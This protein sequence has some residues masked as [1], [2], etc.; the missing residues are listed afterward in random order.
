MWYNLPRNKSLKTHKQVTMINQFDKAKSA[1]TS[2]LRRLSTLTSKKPSLPPPAL[3]GAQNCKRSG[4]I[5]PLPPST[6]I[7]ILDLPLEIQLLIFSHLTI[8]DRQALR[9]SSHFF[10]D[11]LPPPTHD[12]LLD[13]ERE[14]AGYFHFHH[15]YPSHEN[16]FSPVPD[17]FDCA[18][19]R[20]LPPAEVSIDRKSVV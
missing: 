8:W 7:P 4:C 11:L 1:V 17:V 16:A 15:T 6:P 13:A 14:W 12:E 18:T 2:S 20:S 10:H 5:I 9:H 19:K 3:C